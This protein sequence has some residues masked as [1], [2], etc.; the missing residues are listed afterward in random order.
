MRKQLVIGLGEVGTAI[1]R[2][3]GCDG[4][5]PARMVLKVDKQY[6]V[7]HICFPYHD[8]DTFNDAVREYVAFHTPSL[9]IIHSTVPVGTSAIHGAV[10]SPIRGLHPNLEQGI[11][12]FV[13]FFGG[14]KAE[15]AALL[16]SDLGI[17]C[18]VTDKAENTEAMKLWDT[19]QYGMAILLQQEIH[20]YCQDHGLD[21]SVVYT[22]ANHTYN[23][24]YAALGR[25]EYAKYVLKHVPGRIGGHCVVPNARLIDTSSAD[26][27]LYSQGEFS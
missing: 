15:E 21:F 25:P 14:P 16:F 22:E 24:G 27:L 11:R 8:A 6:D 26:R 5:D 18:L 7:L 10:H 2:I 4:Y 3:L 13:K 23:Q 12:T 1:Q 17:K 20:E 9:V 19:L